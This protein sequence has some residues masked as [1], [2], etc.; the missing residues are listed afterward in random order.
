[1]PDELDDESPDDRL[2]QDL[3]GDWA[4][5]VEDFYKEASNLAASLTKRE[6]GTIA[7]ISQKI[8]LKNLEGR[9]R[10]LVKPEL[11]QAL[12]RN[13]RLS[14]RKTNEDSYTIVSYSPFDPIQVPKRIYDALDFF[15]G[16]R[17][18]SEVQRLIAR[19]LKMALEKDLLLSL[20]QLRI[21][22]ES[23]S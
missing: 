6:F 11:P 13:P 2:L 20:Y 16:R 5:R 23:E 1:M 9:Q 10:R 3:W 15:D 18:A 17:K 12:V 22:V 21:L 4:L 8:L 19:E 14:V 7:G